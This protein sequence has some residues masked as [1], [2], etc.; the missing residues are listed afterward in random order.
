MRRESLRDLRS[1]P[2]RR[3]P[4][5]E[6]DQEIDVGILAC[7]TPRVGP[8]QDH[9]LRFVGCRQVRNQ[10]MNF[11]QGRHGHISERPIVG[12]RAQLP[13]TA[14][15]RKR[16]RGEFRLPRTEPCIRP[17]IGR[18]SI[19]KLLWGNGL[20]AVAGRLYAGSPAFLDPTAHCHHNTG[21][22]LSLNGFRGWSTSVYAIFEDSGRQYKVSAGDKIYVDLRE[23][24]EGQDTI[25]F[26]NVLALGEGEASRFGQPYLQGAKV[27]G[28]LGAEVKGEKIWGTQY[29]RRK[30]Y[31]RTWGHRQSYLP[32]TISEIV[33]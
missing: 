23:L 24:S 32:V 2:Q 8:E 33:G 25:E 15:K 14:P 6:F 28:K 9:P 30:R 3:V 20:C 10:I 19:C 4:Q 21:L 26:N 27:V 13:W 17:R 16:N 29:R 11:I 22:D 31:R 1:D 5:V 7:L 18:C 12:C